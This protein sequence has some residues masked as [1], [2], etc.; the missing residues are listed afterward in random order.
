MLQS[1]KLAGLICALLAGCLRSEVSGGG[2]SSQP[3][4][5]PDAP[6]AVEAT[7]G[8]GQAFVRWVP[9]ASNGGS[10]IT[11]Y[12]VASNPGNVH[13]T[14]ASTAA[15]IPGLANGTPYTFTVFATNAA[16]NGPPSSP[17]AAVTPVAGAGPSFP[18][19]ASANGRYLVDAKGAPFRIQGDAAFSLIANLTFAEAQTYLS[20]RQAKGFNAILVNLLEH[21]F[22]VN[23]PRNRNGDAP[24]T[25]AGNF[26]TPNEAY[27]SF[28]DA[29]IDLAASK[30]MLVLLEYLYLGVSGGDEGWYGVMTSAPNTQ[31]V[32]LQF[33]QYLGNRYKN[34]P[35]IVWVSGGDFGPPTGSEGEA[36]HH[37]ILEGIRAAGATQLATAHWSVPSIGTD[38][39]TFA[40]T[41]TLNSA[42]V[43]EKQYTVAADAFR[44]S[45]TLPAFLIETGYEQEGWVPG[46][47]ASVRKYEYWAA[48]GGATAGVFYGHRDIWEFNTDTWSSGFPFGFQRWQLSLDAPGAQDM[49]RMGQLYGSIAW[50]AL[51]P[52][53][54][55]GMKT[56]VTATTSADQVTAAAAPDGSVLLAYVPPKGTSAVTVTIDMTAMGGATRSRW[57]DPTTGGYTPDATGLA[58]TGTHVFTTPGANASGAN[59]WVLVLDR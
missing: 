32:C 41:V 56:L 3:A 58:N 19:S 40:P 38:D 48:L 23:P 12:S 9:P 27:F 2:G 1:P 25:T 44:H 33:G 20:D 54:L 5:P 59:D 4:T 57:F 8:D 45:P 30:G 51:V 31:A 52:S 14:V 39:P 50:Q 22:A 11:T 49:T 37:K 24:F 21:K 6:T 43:Y 46:D 42:Y 17:S 7:P 55:A 36:R 26:S 18:V 15:A 28:A 29:V 10:A 35:N 13:A 16:G 47:R 34:R 53:G